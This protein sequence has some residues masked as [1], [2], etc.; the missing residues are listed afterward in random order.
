VKHILYS[1]LDEPMIP[2]YPIIEIFT[3]SDFDS[4]DTSFV[5]SFDSF[6]V[7]SA[8]INVDHLGTIIVCNSFNQELMG[9]ILIS[10]LSEQKV[11]GVSFFIDCPVQAHPLTLYF[12][13]R[14]VHS[15]R[16]ANCL[17]SFLNVVSIRGVN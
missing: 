12:D 7:R 10:P 9:C 17:L 13:I 6:F 16:V 3:L 8:V 4:F 11:N 2:F 1:P 15:P 5:I 14:F